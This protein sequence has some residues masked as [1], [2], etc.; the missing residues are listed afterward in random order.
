[1]IGKLLMI[2]SHEVEDRGMNIV[3]RGAVYSGVVSYFVCFTIAGASLD[4]A[5]SHP[6]GKTKRVVIASIAALFLRS[7]PEFSS[8]Y[9]QS[10]IEKSPLFEVLQQACDGLVRGGT[11]L[12]VI[13]HNAAVSIP[14]IIPV[15]STRVKLYKAHPALNETPCHEALAPEIFPRVSAFN[16]IET[17][18]RFLLLRNIQ[19]LGSG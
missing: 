2:D 8:P 9:Y 17:S 19:C 15:P 13:A 10:L 1:M 14:V 4:A 11:V 7:T 6:H 3:N 16:A 18:G 5:S 12:I